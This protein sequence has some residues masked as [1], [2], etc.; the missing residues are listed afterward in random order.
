MGFRRKQSLPRGFNADALTALAEKLI[1]A[2]G[3]N[4]CL[5]VVQELRALAKPTR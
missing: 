1:T 2:T 3:R 4:Y 5:T